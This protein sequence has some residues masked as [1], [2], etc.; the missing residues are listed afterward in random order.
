MW[1]SSV[2]LI[3]RWLVGSPEIP[4]HLELVGGIVVEL[5]GGLGYGVFDDGG[6]GVLGAVVVDVDALVGGGFV[7]AD[8]VGGGGGR[9]GGLLL[10][11]ANWRM[12]ETRVAGRVSKR[13][14]GNQRLR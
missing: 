8:G 6:G 13:K 1:R 11:R 2:D 5:L 9:R 7:E 12:T 10:M 3:R 14:L 4:A